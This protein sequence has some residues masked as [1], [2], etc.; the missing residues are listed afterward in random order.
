M[1]GLFNTLSGKLMQSGNANP[2]AYSV[3]VIISLLIAAHL[4]YRSP[5]FPFSP[6]SASYIEQARNLIE[7]GNALNTPYGL[8]PADTDQ[9]ENRLFPI[10]YALVLAA[11]SSLGLDAKYS[12]VALAY[13]SAAILPCLLFFGF[14]KALGYVGALFLAVLVLSSPGLLGQAPMGLTDVFSLSLAVAAIGLILNANRL[15]AYFAAGVFAGV[16]YAVRNVH[17]ALLVT[18]ALYFCYC[19]VVADRLGRRLVVRQ[20]VGTF[21]GIGI[22]VFP[23]LIRNIILFGSANPYQMEQSTIGVVENV[24]TYI[25]ALTKD[26][27]ACGECA[28]YVAWSMPGL[29]LLV[30]TALVICWWL[31]KYLWRNLN[32]LE[33]NTLVISAVYFIVGSCVVIAARS[34]YQWGEPINLRHTLQYTPFLLVVLLM[35]T[36]RLPK[37][38]LDYR[39]SSV[40]NILMLVLVCFHVAYSLTAENFQRKDKAFY[41]NLL[42]A[43]ELGKAHLC[44]QESNVFLVSNWAYVFR[45]E[46]GAKVRQIEAVSNY[47]DSAKGLQP[48][49]PPKDD[50]DSLMGVISVIKEQTGS[51]P[52]HVGFF[53][54]SFGVKAQDLP[55]S[56][57]MQKQLL[58][59][60]WLIIRNDQR[61]LL[62]EHPQ[63][64]S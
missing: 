17:L 10:G 50:H 46:C 33:R 32:N 28:R 40:R 37:Q 53:P 26:L 11:I 8:S 20:A 14:R 57:L 21:S 15:L 16:A 9:V 60:G 51:R 64:G 55:V 3:L 6:D 35:S 39:S 48:L 22:V 2:L 13:L 43:Y 18:F 31:R 59:N 30:V 25:E 56:D 58:E 41:P 27:L 42:S 23:L 38:L 24:R 62:L 36:F 12:S 34:R 47:G 29:F 63:S 7:N 61:G 45:I 19:W 5:I 1:R 49:M 52:I 54:G 44:A 4:Y